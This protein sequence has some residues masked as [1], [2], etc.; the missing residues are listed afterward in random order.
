MQQTKF[1]P[2]HRLTQVA[3]CRAAV[4]RS[5]AARSH[6]IQAAQLMQQAEQ[7]S[8]EAAHTAS[9][10]LVAANVAVA[11]EH[12]AS[13]A[14][15]WLLT[16]DAGQL[17]MRQQAN[18]RAQDR[19][20][21][22]AAA[23]AATVAASRGVEM[24][25]LQHTTLQQLL[26]LLHGLSS[27]A[28]EAARCQGKVALLSDQDLSPGTTA[29]QDLNAARDRAKASMLRLTQ[30]LQAAQHSM[31]TASA[32]SKA[33]RQHK[34]H[35]AATFKQASANPEDSLQLRADVEAAAHAADAAADAA[36]SM[37]HE[38]VVLKT[39]SSAF[40]GGQ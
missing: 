11:Q 27:A 18:V 23:V 10:A 17:T 4:E 7:Y 1:P 37:V 33:R 31:Q 2:F 12:E 16:A 40:A 26:P 5:L 24:A 14:D 36:R 30:L 35:V 34:E 3:S 13:E 39:V 6:Y 28:S 19:A 9:Q 8:Q 32:I 15:T 25:C 20:G 22:A 38:M 21:Q 29:C